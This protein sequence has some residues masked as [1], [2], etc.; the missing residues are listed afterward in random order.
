[1]SC[2]DNR[3][4]DT[5][6]ETQRRV[7]EKYPTM[8]DDEVNTKVAKTWVEWKNV[9]MNKTEKDI[10][11]SIAKDGVFIGHIKGTKQKQIVE[12][13][14]A[15]RMR[16]GHT[17]VYLANDTNY[18][19]KYGSGE[20]M[21]TAK[22]MIVTSA[23]V[24]DAI[25]AN[26][27]LGSTPKNTKLDVSTFTKYEG[28]LHGD[29][30]AMKQFVDQLNEMDN[31]IE[32]DENIAELKSLLD[33]LDP[34]MMGK[35]KTYYKEGTLDTHGAISG[36]RIAISIS[37]NHNSGKSAA[38]VYVHEVIHSY[39]MAAIAMAAAGDVKARKIVRQLETLMNTAHTALKKDGSV[40]KET[41]KY[42]FESEHSLDEFI[43]HTL[44][45]K[46]VRDLLKTV[47]VS[48]S[49]EHNG[50][51]DTIKA[52]FKTIL[53]IISGNYS[54]ENMKSNVYDATLTLSMRLA[55][56]NN[57]NIQK[58]KSNESLPSRVW[59]AFTAFDEDVLGR[60]LIELKDKVFTDVKLPDIPDSLPG[61]VMWYVKAVVKTATVPGY[62][63][64]ASKIAST[65]GMGPDGTIQTLMRDFFDQDALERE[66]DWTALQSDRIDSGRNDL[67][68]AT[69]FSIFKG[70]DG[71]LET[72]D[73]V[74][75][76]KVIVDTELQSIY[77][78]KKYS[79]SDIVEIL[80]NEKA[81]ETKIG[82]VKARIKKHNA[83]GYNY[84]VNQ[85]TGLGY[86]MATGKIHIAQNTNTIN[87]ASG[88]LTSER[89]GKRGQEFYALVAAL[90]ELATLTAL[91]HTDSH[92]KKSVSALIK[93]QSKGVDNVVALAKLNKGIAK[94][95][96]FEGN[97]TH[98]IQGYSKELF[99]DRITME[100]AEVSD[101][102]DME[103]KGY[104]L[105]KKLKNHSTE[106]ADAP[107]MAM[108]INESFSTGEW[109]RGA[110]RLT[111]LSRKGTSLKAVYGGTDDQFSK[112][113]H[114][115][116]KVKLDKQRY[117]IMAKMKSGELDVT[118][119][120]Y[121]MGA[122]LNEDGQV[123]DYRYMMPKV[124]KER[125]LGT[126]NKISEVLPATRASTYDK[127][128]TAIHNEDVLKLII[129]DAKENYVHKSVTGKND[130]MYT[131]IHPDSTD[132]RI[133]ELWEIMPAS[134]KKA[135]RDSKYKGLP[136][137]TDL[138]GTYF[139]YRHLSITDFPGMEK[140][141]PAVV[142]NFIRIAET[143]WVEFIKIVKV[144]ILIKVPAVIVGNIISNA[145]Y[146]VM[147]GT[148]PLELIKHYT[149]STRDARAYIKDHRELVKLMEAKNSG[150]KLGL[151]IS[152]LPL[153]EKRLKNNPIHELAE[154]G[155]Y[156]AIVEDISHSE[157]ESTNKLKALYN[158][159]AKK[160]PKAIKTGLNW[161][162]LTEE[163]GV[164]KFSAEVLQISDLVARDVEN[165]K[166][167][168]LEVSQL[169][170]KRPMPT[171]WDKEMEKPGGR[172]GIPKGPLR[173]R[174]LEESKKRRLD[175]VLNAFINYNKISGSKEEYLNRMGLIMFTKYAK[176]IQKVIANTS[177]KYPLKSLGMLLGQSYIYDFETIQD[178]QVVTRSWYNLGLGNGDIVPGLS[179]FTHI[180]NV[181]EPAL[182]Q[183]STYRF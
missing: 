19:F 149:E 146:A 65:W 1:M 24:R 98:M 177:T 135:A 73:D 110:T 151:D 94:N 150:N 133:K 139:G 34:T 155:V 158:E 164:Y 154:S 106:R 27:V 170:G 69:A 46:K 183:P 20:S 120:D 160:M 18:T 70:F 152:K 6:K 80:E 90:D 113:K 36:K 130:K 171:W 92:H 95:T 104:R 10:Y 29:I 109:H 102:A 12:P 59:E 173:K 55:E 131:L 86:F 42:M 44:T 145:A 5:F 123:V 84:L 168:A 141:T 112:I 157:F 9:P 74:A 15:V 82:R 172:S 79:R 96:V 23:L 97:K 21:K 43:A 148:N 61:K 54:L 38:E 143:M 117:E 7:R 93:A 11:K 156:Q 22:G 3:H 49:R 169:T 161:L 121:G 176:R 56:S 30:D 62:R 60:K 35:F 167:K 132:K 87:I 17:T 137:R 85:A 68:S 67:K 166:L 180:M 78:T 81:L 136:V 163:T 111:K 77:N 48:K 33:M 47:D 63:N 134:F 64:Q 41:M 101:K 124:D 58:A 179:P 31:N 45:N 13:I 16:N 105:V 165:R 140:F 2:I 178:Q 126:D 50:I 26:K 125:Y 14:V 53:D 88:I 103:K 100:I 118:K 138:M 153:L 83:K 40:D 122:V 182:I 116:V 89:V 71:K 72:E 142:R 119:L 39:T 76:K 51:V 127:E 159:K 144:D 115:T 129:D 147:T 99:D 174:F 107:K 28:K 32:S 75:L 52:L 91:K 108:Y 4:Y 175:T 181:L 162:F 128:N 66:V 57:H 114:R 37:G 8:T 25:P